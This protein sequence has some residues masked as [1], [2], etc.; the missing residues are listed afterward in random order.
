MFLCV[1][2]SSQFTEAE[3]SHVSAMDCKTKELQ[4]EFDAELNQ[5]KDRL[6]KVCVEDAQAT[7]ELVNVLLM[8]N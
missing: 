2:V 8:W 3:E 1:C 4:A 6:Q 7:H 5:L